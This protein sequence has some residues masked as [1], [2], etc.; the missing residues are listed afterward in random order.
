VCVCVL[1]CAHACVTGV[2]VTHSDAVNSEAAQDAQL[3]KLR[4]HVV[5]AHGQGGFLWGLLQMGQRMWEDENEKRLATS[6]CIMW[7][8]GD[9]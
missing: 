4:Q 3:L 9:E 6:S 8:L 1:V 5:V 7:T 2:P